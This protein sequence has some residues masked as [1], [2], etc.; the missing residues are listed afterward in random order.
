MATHVRKNITLP[1]SLDERLRSAARRRGTSQSRL[2]A[3]L[4]EVGLAA[5][6]GEADPLLAYLGLIDGP[7]DLSETVDK[8]VYAR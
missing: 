2:I 1:Q 3:H 5:E 4:V 6:L 8:T 7:A